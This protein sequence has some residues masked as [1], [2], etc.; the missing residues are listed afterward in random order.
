M[1]VNIIQ[2]E[3]EVFWGVVLHFHK[4]KCHSV[5]DGEMLPI[6]MRKLDNISVWQMYR[7]KARFVGFLVIYSVSRSKLGLWEISKTSNDCSTKTYAA[8]LAATSIFRTALRLALA[9]C[10]GLAHGVGRSGCGVMNSPS[11]GDHFSRRYQTAPWETFAATRPSSQFTLGRLVTPS[12]NCFVSKFFG[13][14]STVCRSKLWCGK[15]WIWLHF[16]CQV[17]IYGI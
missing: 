6:R 13:K 5:A 17:F 11:S 8:P 3:G 14:P 15:I 1:G 2:R 16:R 7:W 12:V 4:G 9:M 10:V